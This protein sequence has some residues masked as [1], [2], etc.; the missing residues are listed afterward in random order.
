MSAAD[1][2]AL[3]AAVS[4]VDGVT[5][6]PYYR[7]ALGPGQ[8]MV[9]L[10]RT[11]PAANGFGHVNTWQIWIG[12]PQDMTAAEM[13]IDDHAQALLAAL[14]RE[15]VGTRATPAEL[16]ITPGS[17]AVYGLVLEGSRGA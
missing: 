2:Q 6:T 13:W 10:A 14:K 7:Q 3:A 5:C 17:P 12:L 1:R 15:L 4:T 11:E 16:V 9:R 8:G